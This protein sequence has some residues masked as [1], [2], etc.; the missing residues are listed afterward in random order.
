MDC[1]A[2]PAPRITRIAANLSS[3]PAELIEPVI[4]KLELR[5]IFAL[6]VSPA[7]GPALLS[8]IENSPAWAWLFRYSADSSGF[9]RLKN[10]WFAFSQL[11]LL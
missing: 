4:G 2:P 7:A 9:H 11:A 1:L 8:A 10:V 5:S 3:F 6:F